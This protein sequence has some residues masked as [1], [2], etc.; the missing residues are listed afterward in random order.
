MGRER[1]LEIMN[2]Y[3]AEKQPPQVLATLEQQSPKELLK[4]SLDVVDFLLYLEEETGCEIDV[5]ALG[6]TIV[7]RN[8]GELADE[9]ARRL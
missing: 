6:E 2:G 8:F 3:F 9:L 4:E 5:N 7:N 1:V